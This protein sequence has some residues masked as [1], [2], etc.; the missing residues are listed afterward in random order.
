MPP[1]PRPNKEEREEKVGVED[2]GDALFGSGINL[3]DEEAALSRSYRDSFE[4]STLS[5]GNSFDLLTQSANGDARCEHL[6]R[7]LG[8][9]AP[10]FEQTEVDLEFA[11]KRQAAA[12][13]KAEKCQHHLNNPFLL[14]NVLRLRADSLA[15]EGGVALDVNG[16]YVKN[17]PEP[18]T[19][20]MMNGDNTQGIV[21]AESKIE[22]GVPFAEVLSLISLAANE[23]MRNLID[24]AHAI[25]RARRYGDHGR[26]PPEFADLATGDGERRTEQLKPENISN[27]PWDR[28]ED[29]SQALPTISHQSRINTALRDLATRDTE[30]ETL[31]LKKRALRAARLAE[32]NPKDEDTLLPD[33]L[34]DP[35]ATI[36][37]NT[38][39]I[40]KKEALRLQKEAKSKSE[41]T[42]AQ[43]TNQTAN[44]MMGNRK[45]K[46]Y[47][48]MTGGSTPGPTNRFAKAP[49][50]SVAATPAPGTPTGSSGAAGTAV[51]G[52]EVAV[53]APDTRKWGEWSEVGP[54]GKGIQGRDWVLVL[55]RDGRE[56]K[57]LQKAL[58]GLRSGE[59][60]VL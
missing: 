30:S 56:R 38:P 58:L 9:L 55:E 50:T 40:S 49:T 42:I 29:D 54:E 25:A 1:P 8:N 33:A 31:R 5:G 6:K 3:K 23:R 52:K 41:E 21:L 46:Q 4:S 35:N 43:T 2:L 27:S 14:G 13:A 32:S 19:T 16:L 26:V 60:S 45:G 17:R 44:M 20:V 51:L 37:D 22:H 57:A 39:K 28:V 59:K 10:R 34:L 7:Q 18:S 15:K 36:T 11:V 47:S 24:E 12:R 48:W 53:S